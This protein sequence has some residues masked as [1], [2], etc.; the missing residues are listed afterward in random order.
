LANAKT[1]TKE[2]EGEFKL[3]IFRFAADGNVS[4]PSQNGRWCIQQNFMYNI[5][6]EKFAATANNKDT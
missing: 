4:M 5:M 2:V 1:L 6:H 3:V